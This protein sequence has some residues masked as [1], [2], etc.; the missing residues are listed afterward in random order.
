[1]ASDH[2][3]TL[4]ILDSMDRRGAET[5]AVQM[6]DRLDRSRFAPH[7][8]TTRPTASQN[9]LTPARTPV[10]SRHG[11]GRWPTVRSMMELVGVIRTVR[12]QIIQCHGAR[13]LKYAVAVKPLGRSPAYVYNKILSI[14][15]VLDH[16]V[17]RILYRIFFEQVDAVVA[18][19]EQIRR[20]VETAFRPRRP[21]LLTINNG[22]SVGVFASV[23]AAEREERRRE[24]ALTSDRVCLMAVGNLSWEKDPHYLVQLCAELITDHRVMLIFVGYGPMEAGLRADVERLRLSQHVRFLGVRSDIPQLLAAADILLLPSAVEGLPGT[25]IEAGM[26]GRPAVAFR[27][28]AVDDVLVDGVTGF[29]VPFRDTDLFRRRTVE[30]I[31]DAETRVRMGA[32]AM[33]RCRTEFD[34]ERSVKQYEA[35]FIDLVAQAQRRNAHD[36]HQ[37]SP[38]IAEEVR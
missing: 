22:R 37:P 33:V 24:M 20:E 2:I 11:P 18:V 25:L 19:G 35:L 21:R 10:L 34:I 29:T 4:H 36:G 27:V 17:K 8:W 1:M 6:I 14:H 30:L 38:N 26:A 28:G 15:P 9:P 12:P 31:S 7:I 23:T 5:F 32:A 16:P 3:R 13:P